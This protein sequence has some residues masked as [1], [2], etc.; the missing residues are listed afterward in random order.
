MKLEDTI[1]VEQTLE[2]L[3]TGIPVYFVTVVKTTGSSPRPVGSIMSINQDGTFVGSVSSGCIEE[4]LREKLLKDTGVTKFPACFEYGGSKAEAERLQLPCGATIK[5][6][7]ESINKSTD[8]EIIKKNLKEGKTSLRTLDF[9]TGDTHVSSSENAD[10]FSYSD[11]K[12][13]R[14]FG[15]TWQLLLVG[16]GDVS[17]YLAQMAEALNYQVTVCEPRNEY[18]ES[19]ILDNS[20]LDN[21]M[22]DD[23]INSIPGINR[24]A[25]VALTHDPRLDDLAMLEALSSGAF[26]IGALGSTRNNE[27]RKER[28]RSMSVSEK[29]IEKLHGPVGLSIGSKT[30]AEIAVSIMAEIIAVRSTLKADHE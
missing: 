12:L 9:D 15:P 30:P 3:K 21:R 11:G 2:W 27:K 8:F 16:A 24:C 1:V 26:Y 29:D 23:I 18:T 28:L 7:V 6:L 17:Y 14:I 20:I 25:I 4:L 13:K 10:A 19:W 5:L 22:P